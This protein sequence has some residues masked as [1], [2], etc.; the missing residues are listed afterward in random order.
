MPPGARRV[1]RG[2]VGV[3]GGDP[4]E[5]SWRE[6]IIDELCYR[7]W[8]SSS[9]E[10][11]ERI[12]VIRWGRAIRQGLP[13]EEA[14]YELMPTVRTFGLPVPYAPKGKV[15]ATLGS[16]VMEYSWEVGYTWESPDLLQA[17]VEVLLLTPG[18]SDDHPR[19]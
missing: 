18:P 8:V 6:S 3:E 11:V 7:V 5:R 10:R 17:P 15:T 1:A 19:T 2:H 14:D 16:T 4:Y 9:G 12:K 13:I